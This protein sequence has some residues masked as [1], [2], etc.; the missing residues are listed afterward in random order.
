LSSE[1]LLLFLSPHPKALTP[2][3][4][5]TQKI[6]PPSEGFK[7]RSIFTGTNQRIGRLISNCFY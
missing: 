7:A 6:P 1:R 4:D 2:Q 3:P 5:D